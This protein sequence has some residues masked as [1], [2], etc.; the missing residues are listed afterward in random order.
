VPGI[1]LKPFSTTSFRLT[2]TMFSRCQHA[3]QERVAAGSKTAM[4]KVRNN[5]EFVGKDTRYSWDAGLT[6]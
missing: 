3:T 4:I 2:R 6:R 5:G 1:K